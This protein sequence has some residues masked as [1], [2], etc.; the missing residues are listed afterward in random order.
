MTPEDLGNM[1]GY[2]QMYV[3]EIQSK[4]PVLLNP[5]STAADLKDAHDVIDSDMNSM[6]QLLNTACN[7]KQVQVDQTQLS[8]YD[9]TKMNLLNNTSGIDVVAQSVDAN[10]AAA[11]S[12]DQPIAE[13]KQTA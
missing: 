7:M 4:I 2:L 8:T 13:P 3:I 6:Y 5:D 12:P 10:D 1:V 11:T 9:L